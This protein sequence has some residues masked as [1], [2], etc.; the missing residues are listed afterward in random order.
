MTHS[1][2]ACIALLAVVSFTARGEAQG[3]T[4]GEVAAAGAALGAA[5][6]LDRTF[7]GTVPDRGGERF[8]SLGETLNHGGRPGYAV[9]LLLGA[10]A[11]GEIAGEPRVAEAAV[12]VGA[13]LAAGGIANGVLKYSVGRLRP[14]RT[15]DPLRFRP[16]SPENRWQSFPSGHAVV[17][18]SLAAAVSE[19]ARRPWVTALAYGAA[20]AVAWSRVYDDKHWTSDAVGGALVGIAAGRTTVWL[21]H[22][23]RAAVLAGPGVLGIT[24]PAR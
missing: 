7:D 12:H 15:D 19:E 13:A 22:R 21:L 24:L 1:R 10:W 6:L 14:N 20:S 3:W 5:L 16:F 8:E 9:V 17:A 23:R 2:I 4:R 11:G 18:F